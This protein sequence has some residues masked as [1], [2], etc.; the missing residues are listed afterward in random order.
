MAL[1]NYTTTVPA[2]RTVGQV[3]EL[4]V[5]A[6]ASSLSM[7][8]ADDG[9]IDGLTFVVDTNYGKRAFTLPVNAD[10][11]ERVMRRDAKVPQRLKNTAQARRVAWRILKDWVEAQLAIIE[12]EM[13]TLDQVMLP[14]MEGDDGMT[15]YELYVGQQ[16]ALNA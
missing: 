1:L 11:V 6:G 3:Q 10:A 2:Q 8:I 14:Y 15:V 9:Y 13:A 7:R 4:L 5:R 12:T 16:R